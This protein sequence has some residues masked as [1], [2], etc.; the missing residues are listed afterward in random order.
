MN[1][2][3]QIDAPPLSD[4]TY[5]LIASISQ[6]LSANAPSGYEI[7][8]REQLKAGLI[9]L[10][11]HK[12]DHFTPLKAF[13]L[14]EWKEGLAKDLMLSKMNKNISVAEVAEACSLSRSHFSRAFKHSTGVSPKEWFMTMKMERAKNLLAANA[15]TLSGI[16]L[17]CGFSDQ[18]HFSRTFVKNVGMTPHAWRIK[19][20]DG[21]APVPQRR[22]KH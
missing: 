1:K 17:E 9:A 15:C 4:G 13:G 7:I 8:L 3:I 12:E 2:P 10:S 20:G 21:N 11:M 18:S 5:E 14:P 6:A 19:H 22:K 16:S